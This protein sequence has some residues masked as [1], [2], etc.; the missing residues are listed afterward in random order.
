M[1]QLEAFAAVISTGSIT[2][3]ARKLGR[4]QPTVTRLIRELETS[5][6]RE[7]FQRSGPRVSPLDSGYEFYRQIEPALQRLREARSY[8]E[9]G[10]TIRV[11]TLRVAATHEL[12]ASLLPAA[13]ANWNRPDIPVS[14][15]GHS[16]EV[17][18]QLVQ[19][20]LVDIGLNSLP[21]EHQGLQI[22]WLGEG[23]RLAAVR[24]DDPLAAK[25][26][27]ALTDFHGRRMI[28]LSNPH[29]AP[30]ALR[31][32]IEDA[33]AGGL[34]SIETNVAIALLMAVQ[35]GLGIAIVHPT[36]AASMSLP[37]VVLRPLEMTLPYTFGAITPA[38]RAMVLPHVLDFV[39]V[40]ADTASRIVPDFRL[41]EAQDHARL[42]RHA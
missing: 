9:A 11:P 34:A 1:K 17:V 25:E 4:S 6:G 10:G 33:H 26:R 19:N 28:L 12:A 16:P 35:A 37:D 27:I 39:Q 23:P 42:L 31:G 21:L 30:D 32:L 2:A 38:G 7:L 40:L 29:R 41:H 18:V 14:I 36:I 3:A 15:Q 22:H 5:L 20:G 8:V 24:A 13:L